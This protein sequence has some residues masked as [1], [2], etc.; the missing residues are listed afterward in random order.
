M[1]TNRGLGR[2]RRGRGEAVAIL[3]NLK[4]NYSKRKKIMEKNHGKEFTE[5]KEQH[6]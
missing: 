3:T 6:A 1:K 2:D 5:R 4:G